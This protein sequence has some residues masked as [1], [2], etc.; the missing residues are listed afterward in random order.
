[1]A[2]SYSA[3]AEVRMDDGRIIRYQP[4]EA[5]NDITPDDFAGFFTGASCPDVSGPCGGGRGPLTPGLHFPSTTAGIGGNI[6]LDGVAKQFNLGE[7]YGFDT[8]SFYMDAPDS[9]LV[10]GLDPYPWCPEKQPPDYLPWY[11]EKDGV[12]AQSSYYCWRAVATLQVEWPYPWGGPNSNMRY[13]ASY[14]GGTLQEVSFVLD[15]VDLLMVS[16]D[17]QTVAINSKTFKQLVVELKTASGVPV[18]F[19]ISLGGTT[20]QTTL[21]TATIVGPSNSAPSIASIDFLGGNKF[22]ITAQVGSKAGDYIVTVKHNDAAPT[23]SVAFTLH[24]ATTVPP[25]DNPQDE[26]GNGSASNDPD[27]MGQGALSLT[28]QAVQMDDKTV[29]QSCEKPAEFAADPVNVTNGNTLRMEVDYAQTGLSP[30]EFTRTYNSKGSVSALMGNY[31]T[32][33]YDRFV[34]PPAGPGQLLRLRRPDGLTIRYAAVGSNYVSDSSFHGT[35]NKNGAGWRYTDTNQ[36][37][38]DYDG[39]GKLVAITDLRGRVQTLTYSKGVLTK[40]SANTGESLTFAYTNNR[41]TSVT[42]QTSRK[43]TYTY[44]AYLNLTSVK[45]PDGSYHSYFYSDPFSPYHLTGVNVGYFFTPYETDAQIAWEYDAEGHSTASYFRDPVVGQ[46]RRTD[47]TFDSDGSTRTVMDGNNNP[48]VYSTQSINGRGFVSSIAGPGTAICGNDLTRQFDSAMNV[49]SKSQAGHVTTFNNFDGKGQFAN[50]VLAVGTAE[51]RSVDYLYDARYYYKPIQVSE[52]SVSPGHTKTATSVYDAYGNVT[53]KTESGFQPNI[54]PMQQPTAISRTWKFQYNGP[55]HQLSQIDGPRSDVSDLTNFTYNAAGRLQKVTDGNGIVRRNNITYTSTGNV[56]SEDRPNGLHIVYAY[57]AGSDLL[58]TVTETQGTLSRV[59]TWTYDAARRI[60]NISFSDGANTTQ[61]TSFDYNGAGQLFYVASEA[62]IIRY[63]FDDQGNPIRDSY[64]TASQGIEKSYVQRTFD[65]YNRVDKII[66]ANNTIDLDFYPDGTLTQAKDG[67]QQTTK[68]FYDGLKRLTKVVRPDQSLIQYAYD[69]G[70]NLDQ[71]IDSNSAMTTYVYDDFHNKVAQISPDTGTT[72]YSHDAAGNLSQLIDANGNVTKFFYDAGNR[73]LTVDRPG[74]TYDESYTYDSCTNGSGLLCSVANGAGETVAYQYNGFGEIAGV[75]SGNKNVS[76]QYDAQSHVTR[77][78]YPSGRI[79]N[80]TFNGGGQVTKVTVTE[81]NNVTTLANEIAYQPFGPVSGWTYGNGLTHVRAYDSQNWTRS[82]STPN[83]SALGYSQYDG[84]GNLKTLTVDGVGDQ[85]TYD[86]FN[87]IKSGSGDFGSRGYSYDPDG[88]RIGLTTDGASSILTYTPNSSRISTR[89]G[90]TYT[91]DANGNTTK[92]L[93]TDGSGGGFQYQYSPHNRL[94]AVYDLLAPSL[95][96]ATYTYNALG[97]RVLKTVA[98]VITRYVYSLDGKLLAEMDGFGNVQQ[99]YV[100]LGEMPIALLGAPQPTTPVT[101][102]VSLDTAGANPTA[103]TIKSDTVAVNGTYYYQSMNKSVQ[104]FAYWNF[105]LPSAGNY[106]VYVWWVGSGEA[107][108]VYTIYDG[109]SFIYVSV[110]STQTKGTWV[111]LGNFHLGLGSGLRLDA[112][113][114][115]V[116]SKAYLAADAARMVL[117]SADAPANPNY[118][119]VHTDHLG[120]PR[121]ITNSN[122]AVV[123]KATYDPFG[124]AAV[125]DDVAG[126]GKHTSMNLRFPGQ[127]FDAESGLHYNYFRDYDPSTG[128]YLESDS[129]GLSAGMNTFS[130]GGRNPLSRTD[131]Y[132]LCVEDFCT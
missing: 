41:I 7:S 27:Q 32:T 93:A 90:W 13:H 125:N 101:Y 19:P 67:N 79:V 112:Q 95:P 120:A 127:Y 117:T 83:V 77:L 96:R 51:Q 54:D 60:T 81:N 37:V 10:S 121:A 46:L 24:A 100:Y 102:D 84:N 62:G 97:Q 124:Q 35:L 3:P 128:R 31:W 21:P 29:P 15:P 50:R 78:T 12:L 34:I 116:S 49:A 52:P 66:G 64:Q 28:D 61:S 99:E 57:Y 4:G 108:N 72:Q 11:V 74:S 56:A 71:V 30:I 26:Q 118:K 85:F 45:Y 39:S 18:N 33:T 122:G 69:A 75:T 107:A 48:A 131:K 44:D 36:N 86:V 104:T 88:N 132:G 114:N 55:Y 115:V 9:P 130:Y 70:G 6:K 20:P 59:A 119:F 92:K 8:V 1:M 63:T 76:Y 106:D 16:G 65:A 89:T 123:W 42:D 14:D 53:Q 22:G 126:T 40:V 58:H 5:A 68:R 111:K 98:G 110:S 91:L 2:G 105:T 43:W 73:L 38:E 17:G 113:K 82:I 80:Y 103:W 109:T 94:T 47:V 23:D 87:E 129:I 25:N